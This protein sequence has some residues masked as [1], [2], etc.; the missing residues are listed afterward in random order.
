ME[1]NKKQRKLVTIKHKKIKSGFRI[2][3][4]S[5]QLGDWLQI[6]Y[7]GILDLGEVHWNIE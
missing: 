3:L 1:R 7:N 2:N 5:W 6:D 4:N